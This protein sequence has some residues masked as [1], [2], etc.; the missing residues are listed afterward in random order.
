MV[1][2]VIAHVLRRQHV[3]PLC[4]L[5]VEVGLGAVLGV[6]AVNALDFHAQACGFAL[7]AD[8]GLDAVDA[9]LGQG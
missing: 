7:A 5:V 3:G 1:L 8:A 2:V 9:F 6:V 4:G